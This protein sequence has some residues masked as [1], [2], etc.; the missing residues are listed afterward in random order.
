VQVRAR[1]S[2]VIAASLAVLAGVLVAGAALLTN[3]AHVLPFVPFWIACLF[4]VGAALRAAGS[5]LDHSLRVGWRLVAVA[6]AI[7]LLAG[8]PQ[9]FGLDA[10]LRE[11]GSSGTGL[12][13][14]YAAFVVGGA[15]LYWLARASRRG[16]VRIG[17]DLVLIT[18]GGITIYAIVLQRVFDANLTAGDF[19]NPLLY[20]PFADAAFIMILSLGLSAKLTGPRIRRSLPWS[21]GGFIS[22]GI[23]H[24]WRVTAD[25]AQISA[26]PAALAIP[27][28]V[29][30]GLIGV[31]ALRFARLH[32]DG[33]RP[34][35]WGVGQRGRAAGVWW[36]V[37]LAI[38]PYTVSM[39]GAG[40]LLLYVG[41]RDQ[42]SATRIWSLLVALLIVC[43]GGAR[44][45]LNYKDSHELYD[46]L[47]ATLRDLERQVSVQTAELRRRN[48][49]L[50]AIHQ[51]ALMSD[52]TLDV[53]SA[54]DGVARQL[55]TTIESDYCRI[56]ANDALTDV[57]ETLG[58][59]RRADDGTMPPSELL[60]LL[61]EFRAAL[62]QRETLYLATPEVPNGMRERAVLDAAAIGATLIVPL[63]T[64][65]RL[66]GYIEA[67]RRATTPFTRDEVF[68]AESIGAHVS[69]AIENAAAYERARFAADHDPVTGLLN[70]RALQERLALEFERCR[71]AGLPLSV[72]MIDLNNFKEFNDRF[73]HQTGDEVLKAI[74]QAIA[75]AAP[76][77][78]SASRYGGDEFTLLMPGYERAQA[79]VVID[80]IHEQVRAFNA[81]HDNGGLEIGLA[82]GIATYPADAQTSSELVAR[83]DQLMYRQ[84][85]SLKSYVD[86]R[87]QTSAH[88]EPQVL[89]D[90]EPHASIPG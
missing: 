5:T 8:I 14:A 4:A 3:P 63:A 15:A 31:A 20:L 42:E 28:V 32:T 72:A 44:Q 54:L 56:S 78:A 86:R 76:A 49:D 16:L 10:R 21:I 11:A 52:R 51:V 48:D 18:V 73:G 23:A 65:E 24:G 71:V 83:A 58:E 70:H 82:A 43:I 67:Y 77:G 75:S 27:Y 80:A 1:Q 68:V 12:L 59:Y 36:H 30:I 64:P 50:E 69:L 47:D 7:A 60:Q 87:R 66:V 79:D 41:D 35:R 33:D 89:T 88:N 45:V 9:A 26:P 61:P 81:R 46:R 25:F 22:L 2:H 19:R 53:R 29:G 34:Q 38:M 90:T 74:G 84:K 57:Y 85:W 6:M 13:L 62:R 37:G 17:L 40:L 39:V 55:G